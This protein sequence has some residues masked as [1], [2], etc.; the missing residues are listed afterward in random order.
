MVFLAFFANHEMKEVSG[1]DDRI[2]MLKQQ[3]NDAASLEKEV[4]EISQ[5]FQQ[6]KMRA[7]S[8]RD[9]SVLPDL[10]AGHERQLKMLVQNHTQLK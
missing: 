4:L 8:L 1:L 7:Q 5:G 10:C 9:A 3:L 6:N 2:H